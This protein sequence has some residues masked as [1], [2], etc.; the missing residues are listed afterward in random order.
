MK[1]LWGKWPNI[2]PAFPFRDSSAR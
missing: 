1:S 2:P